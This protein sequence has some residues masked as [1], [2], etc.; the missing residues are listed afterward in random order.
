MSVSVF[1]AKNLEKTYGR[2]H[3]I[4]DINFE[5]EEG[6]IFGLIGPNGSGKTTTLKILG[7]VLTPFFG[8]AKVGGL[9]VRNAS[10]EVKR[11]VGYIPESPNLYESLTPVEFFNMVSSIREID[12]AK[13]KRRVNYLVDAFEL[14]PYMNQ[15]IGSLSF[16]T[17][18]KVSIVSSFVH[19]PKAIILDEAMNGLDPKTA[20][21]LR[22][23]L[24]EFRR[25]NKG[26]IFSSHVLP[27]AEVI[28]D[29][30]A[31]IKDGKI[32]AK[33]TVDELKKRSQKKNLEDVFLKL[34]ESET[35]VSKVL[36]ALKN[37]IGG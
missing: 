36:D 6:E 8:E 3:A 7:G 15:Y 32:I 23:I 14:E 19:D 29:R 16:G 26:V 37:S 22:G 11:K 9:D 1:R 27:L 2:T 21:I 34:T 20:R 25:K 18:Q 4:K 30:I 33:G 10:I 28:C 35:E 5:V 17:K 31:V 12:E 13:M 24:S